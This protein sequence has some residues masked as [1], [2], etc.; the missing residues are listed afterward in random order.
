MASGGLVGTRDADL[1]FRSWAGKRVRHTSPELAKSKPF[2]SLC[3]CF[4]WIHQRLIIAGVCD[5]GLL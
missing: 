5:M 4:F 3:G 2:H 1:K